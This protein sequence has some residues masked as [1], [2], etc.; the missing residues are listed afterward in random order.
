MRRKRREKVREQ[1]AGTYKGVIRITNNSY[2]YNPNYRVIKNN[3]I[4][5]IFQN[6]EILRT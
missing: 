6:S 1:T 5:K 3:L 2:N 4:D